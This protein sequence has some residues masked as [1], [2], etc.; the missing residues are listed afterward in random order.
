MTVAVFLFSLLGAMALGMPIAYALLLCGVALMYHLDIFDAQI[1]AQNFINGADSFPLMA[2]PFFMLAGEVMNTGGLSRRIVDLALAMVGHI[3]G[4]L[5]YVAIVAACI[6]S[7]LSGSAVG[8]RAAPSRR[9]LPRVVRAG[10]ARAPA[11]GVV[12]PPR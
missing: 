10:A 11:G 2:V 9:L 12:R 6:L 3:R 4:G 8:R 5:G 1:I 7:A